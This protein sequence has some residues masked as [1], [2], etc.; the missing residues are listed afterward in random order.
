MCTVELS[1]LSHTV[2]CDGRREKI[3]GAPTARRTQSPWTEEEPGTESLVGIEA[4]LV[5]VKV[6]VLNM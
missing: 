5:N 6:L 3:Q 2:G 1:R 4:V